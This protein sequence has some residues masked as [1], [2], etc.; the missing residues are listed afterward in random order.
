VPP[1][2][3]HDPSVVVPLLKVTVPVAAEGVTVAVSV[4]LLPTG[5]LVV[6]ADRVVVVAVAAWELVTPESRNRNR[7]AT[8]RHPLRMF[9]DVAGA[10]LRVAAPCEVRIFDI[11][12]PSMMDDWLSRSQRAMGIDR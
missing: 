10:P 1:L 6:E 2:R 3:V 7:I 5:A 4:T 9:V 11:L 8:L 12:K